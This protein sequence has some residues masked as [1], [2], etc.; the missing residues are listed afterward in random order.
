MPYYKNSNNLVT[1]KL[2]FL[3]TVTGE[4]LFCVVFKR[5]NQ[6]NLTLILTNI[7]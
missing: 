3:I 1:V 2:F 5:S 6:T 7:L 4:L